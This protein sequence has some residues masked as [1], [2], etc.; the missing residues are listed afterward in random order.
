MDITQIDLLKVEFRHL[1]EDKQARKNKLHGLSS[2]SELYRPQAA[3][4]Q[5]SYCY[6]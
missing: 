3:A 2:A 1:P 5:R 4:L 6:F